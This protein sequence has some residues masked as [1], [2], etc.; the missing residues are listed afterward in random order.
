M[1][2]ITRDLCG[3]QICVTPDFASFTNPETEPWLRKFYS[4]NE[5]WK[6]EDRRRLLAYAR[7]LLNS[8]YAGH[9]LTFQLF[10][11]SPPFA[12]LLAV[13]RNFDFAESMRIVRESAGLSERVDLTT[14]RRPQQDGTSAS[15]SV[16]ATPA[17]ALSTIPPITSNGPSPSPPLNEAPPLIP[18]KRSLPRS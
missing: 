3:G 9:R 1:M 13:Y 17:S 15:E 16:G 8:D 7:D 4:I 11:Q 14:A 6:A 5:E 2:H 18:T 10:A 12:H